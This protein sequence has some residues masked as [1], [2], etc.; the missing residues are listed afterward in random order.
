MLEQGLTLPLV[1]GLFCGLA[2]GLLGLFLWRL[3]YLD[4]SAE[5]V[6]VAMCAAV[7]ISSAWGF[8]ASFAEASEFTGPHFVEAALDLLRY[9]AWLLFL[10]QVLWRPG[11]QVS[12]ETSDADHRTGPRDR[13]ASAP[14]LIKPLAG[15]AV[16]LVLASA[17]SIGM[18]AIRGDYEAASA[19][20]SVL[21]M[22]GLAVLGL[23]VVEQ[24]FRNLTE[25]SRWAAKPLA[26]GLV[27]WHQSL[28]P[29]GETTVVFRDSA[30]ADD[31]AKT[32][33][34][35]ILQQHG[36]ETVRSL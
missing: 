5:R 2:F 25:D 30:F 1:G 23:V 10:L 11:Q 14:S 8:S 7:G 26:L 15:T 31:V 32:N 4:R 33:L 28:Q 12:P 6:Q 27:A 19:R 17:A 18:R 34:T 16:F 13:P 24:V 3:G 20:Y 9:T 22:L 29:A 36:L 21:P 35:A